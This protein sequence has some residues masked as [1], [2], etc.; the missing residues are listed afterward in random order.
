[1]RCLACN[2]NLS[3]LESTRKY[4]STEEFIDLC[5]RCLETTDIQ[6]TENPQLSHKP[7]EEEVLLEDETDAEV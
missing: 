2:K 5:T 6:Y 3:D 7:I 4:P 1:M